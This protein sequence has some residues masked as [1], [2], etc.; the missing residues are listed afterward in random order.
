MLLTVSHST[1]YRFRRP[2]QLLPHRFVLTPRNSHTLSLES[3][4]IS[5]SPSAQLEWTQDVFG[6]L[7]ATAVLAKCSHVERNQQNGGG[8]EGRRVAAVQNRTTCSQLSFQLFK[9]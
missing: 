5:T 8:S 9:G 3:S 7:I 1:T 2:V 4:S 6:N